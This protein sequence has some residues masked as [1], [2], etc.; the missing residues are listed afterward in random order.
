MPTRFGGLSG[1]GVGVLTLRGI[2]RTGLNSL[3]FTWPGS[4]SISCRSRSRTLWLSATT[5]LF[6]FISACCLQSGIGFR[7]K[8]RLRASHCTKIGDHVHPL[9]RL[10]M[11]F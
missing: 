1:S 11:T 3:G 7:D 10:R 6:Q 4:L 5:G 2:I 9:G 8:A